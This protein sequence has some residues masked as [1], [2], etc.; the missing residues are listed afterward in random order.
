MTQTC[1]TLLLVDDMQI[2]RAILSAMFEGE[3]EI[4]EAEDGA[5]ALTLMRRNRQKIAAVLLDLLMPVKDGYAV[6]QEAAGDED[7]SR[8][9]II[10][11]TA[12]HTPE[13]EVR[14]FDLGAT[15]IIIKPF[16]ARPVKR[17]IQNAVELYR[18]KLHLEELVAE[19]AAR[20]RESNTAL[21]DGLSSVIEHRS[22]ESGQ[23]IRRIRGFTRI[24]LRE[25]AQE[26]PEYG[27]NE[28]TID[29]IASASTLHDI[30]KIAIPD[31]VLNKPGRLTPEEFE[32]MKTHTV[33]GC[34]IL[35][36]LDRM[37]DPEY[38]SYAYNICRYHHERWDGKGY[39]EGLRENN[40][41]ICAQVVAVADCFDAL[42][43]DRV[44]KQAIPEEEACDMI[45]RGECG[46]FSDELLECFK[47][48]QPEFYLLA[49]KYADGLRPADAG[50]EEMPRPVR[51]F[52]GARTA[53]S[54][55]KLS[56]IFRHLNATVLELDWNTGSYRLLYQADHNF[57][58]FLQKRTVNDA[59]AM[60][61]QACVHPEDREKASAQMDGVYHRFFTEGSLE[62]S[63]RY[64]VLDRDTGEYVWY[65]STVLRLGSEDPRRCQ[66]LAVWRRETDRAETR[67]GQMLSPEKAE[68][69][70]V[71]Y[72]RLPTALLRRRNDRELTV[73]R[74]NRGF[75]RLTGYTEEELAA[76]F[77]NRMVCLLDP[78]D[79]D[80][81]LAHSHRQLAVGRELH[82]EY[83]LHSADG[84]TV[85]VLEDSIL[86]REA[87]GREYFQ[88]VL[89]DVTAQKR[90]QEDL[91]QC[92]ER[93]QVA[94][95]REGSIVFEWD[96]ATD[97]FLTSGNWELKLGYQPR[98][99]LQ[100]ALESSTR[101]YPLDIK[102]ILRAIQTIRDG[103]L[104]EEAEFRLIAADGRYRWQWA[105]AAVQLGG[106]GR[107]C[108]VI[109]VIS[110]VEEEKQ[111]AQELADQS[112]RDGLTG[113]FHKEV[114]R[115]RIDVR[116]AAMEESET[117]AM[118]VLDVDGFR[119]V[120][121]RYGHIFGDAVLSELAGVVKRTYRDGE[122]AAR[123]GGDVFLVFLPSVFSQSSVLDG[124]H[125]LL[126]ACENV[127]RYSGR[128]ISCSVGVAMA[129]AHGQ[130]CETLLQRCGHALCQA[131]ET[132]GGI[133]VL[134]E[135]DF[136]AETGKL[137]DLP[138]AEIDPETDVQMGLS[139]ILGEI[140]RDCRLSGGTEEAVA[141]ALEK[142][143]RLFHVS[144]VYLYESSADGEY[145]FNTFEWCGEGVAPLRAAR[146]ST[147]CR[148]KDMYC[149]QSFDA[150]GIFLC[151]EGETLSAPHK[152]L[153]E[154]R[155][156]R[157]ILRC[158][159]RENGY[160]LGFLGFDDCQFHRS[161]TGM[162]AEALSLA[163]K[164]IFTL[165]MQSREPG[166]IRYTTEED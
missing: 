5:Q 36:G 160:L 49:R 73:T 18:H 128:P 25:V 10:V 124:A 63:S 74:M 120:N 105:K 47:T 145:C 102:N 51:A 30:G 28:H 157:S 150:R 19:Q 38:L 40:I 46:V 131:K 64:R 58:V 164:V 41:P 134:G 2:N 35:A 106:D 95:Q 22:L 113:L 32:V 114:A 142:L 78:V 43:T 140:L 34:E 109:G 7:L 163:A 67:A 69:P 14:V 100:K 70:S 99:Y 126:N 68:K 103:A 13:S 52:A 84:R 59:G 144:R 132:G 96:I 135:A 123:I 44:Y 71:L 147:R 133:A 107:P 39:P 98:S 54:Q 138:Y 17:R 153:L 88:C 97:R 162:Q 139:R 33:K 121:D 117:A 66:G 166:E 156:A 149:H 29:V 6:L 110:D 141:G 143:G 48:A 148:S 155:S 21:I 42:T 146:Q 62:D 92:L 61:V 60:F 81:M 27:M 91:R 79:R 82:L 125:R 3:Y 159:V 93:Y 137:G 8:I 65:R 20:I 154:E 151:R 85:W 130:D 119:R 127:M 15:D 87:D 77:Q 136:S 11:I 152:R 56:A 94:V 115:E 161:W 12:D 122:I 86:R 116:L 112:K 80:R 53:R 37:S 158:A 9:P 72:N 75:L 76:Q 23:H 104:R 111:A 50:A 90:V 1:N 118:L 89:T 129:P 55:D 165:L 16:E 26:H 101:I 57:S 4:L 83:R 24:L 45:L 108:R 31:A